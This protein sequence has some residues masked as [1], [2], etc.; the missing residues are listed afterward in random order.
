MRR[1]RTF[2]F[3]SYSYKRTSQYHSQIH[4]QTHTYARAHRHDVKRERRAYNVLKI[5]T[6]RIR[7]S[8]TGGSQNVQPS[9][10]ARSVCA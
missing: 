4:T 8:T 5:N 7:R 1:R 10:L 3:D 2:N 9:T 6:V